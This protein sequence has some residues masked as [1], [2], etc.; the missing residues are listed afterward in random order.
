MK[1]RY[2]AR[3]AVAAAALA[4]AGA[5]FG[6]T[7]KSGDWILVDLNSKGTTAASFERLGHPISPGQVACMTNNYRARSQDLIFALNPEH[8][9]ARVAIL[10]EPNLP[11][12][13]FKS[14][15]LSDSPVAAPLFES[16]E[17]CF[18]PLDFLG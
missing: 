3:V 9:K 10:A 5:A 4:A 14:T 13:S 17:T 15:K 16:A 2:G 11:D 1:H 12:G 18:I 7:I 6:A 8:K